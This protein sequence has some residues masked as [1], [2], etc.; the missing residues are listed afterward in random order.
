MSIMFAVIE[1]GG[2]Q[3][4]AQPG[5]KIKVEK[6][7]V[8]EEGQVV[9]DKVLLVNDDKDVKIGA[10]FLSGASVTAKVLKQGR[11][12]KKIVFKFHSKNRFDKK[13]TH[14]QSYTE[15]EIDSIK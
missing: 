14:R 10:P 11:D 9:F 2:K 6:L 7:E 5:V 12:D 4:I 3:Y 1:T 8:A 13:K 15:V